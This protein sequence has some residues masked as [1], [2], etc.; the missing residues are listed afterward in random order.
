MVQY[1]ANNPNA[2]KCLFIQNKAKE[3]PLD[4]ALLCN[5]AEIVKI[6]L[7]HDPS[8][9]STLRK[10]LEYSFHYNR[11]GI[12]H[13]SGNYLHYSITNAHEKTF[14]LLCMHASVNMH[15]NLNEGYKRHPHVGDGTFSDLTVEQHIDKSK[16]LLQQDRKILIETDAALGYNNHA[17]IIKEIQDMESSLTVM[18]SHYTKRKFLDE[19]DYSV[20]IALYF[21]K[22]PK[23]NSDVLA[24]VANF[25]IHVP[26]SKSSA[27]DVMT[28]SLTSIDTALTK[29]KQK[30]QQQTNSINWGRAAVMISF[31]RANRDNPLRYSVL[32]LLNRFA[33]LIAENPQHSNTA[34]AITIAS[35]SAN[36]AAN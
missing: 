11:I 29:L 21:K 5:Q 26:D 34:T 22:H 30:K 13:F 15:D 31:V 6:I 25:L 14:K 7:R 18:L 24:H 20:N 10:P 23:L 12:Y 32:G 3:T 9:I 16:A 27:E 28:K 2:V 36:T 1:E 4:V 33:P 19:A 8:Q 17:D 35:G